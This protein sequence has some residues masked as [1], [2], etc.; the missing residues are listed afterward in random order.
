MSSKGN[1]DL[2]DLWWQR[3]QAIICLAAKIATREAYLMDL[4]HVTIV[5]VIQ[6]TIVLDFWNSNMMRRDSRS[7]QKSITD[8][9]A[10]LAF[11]GR[12]VCWKELHKEHQ[13]R[14]FLFLAILCGWT[15]SSKWWKPMC[16]HFQG[17]IFMKEELT[18]IPIL[19]HQ[20]GNAPEQ[21]P[22]D[23][24]HCATTSTPPSDLL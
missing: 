22:T 12:F 14:S 23:N 2:C 17:N 11:W 4:I 15:F 24:L 5:L 3:L 10:T 21:Y 6:S 20:Q 13:L 16:D 8:N 18:A 7:L 9:N 19:D 1:F